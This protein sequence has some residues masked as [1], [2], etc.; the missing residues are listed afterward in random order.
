MAV[1]KEEFEVSKESRELGKGMNAFIAKTR[2]ALADGWQP[3]QDLPLIMSAAIADL[4]PAVQGV[5]L[6]A[7]ELEENRKAFL[8]A[9]AASGVE[10]LDSFLPKK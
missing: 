7:G 2:L 3:G 9:H 1:V 4:V 8:M 6:V 10:L 5:E